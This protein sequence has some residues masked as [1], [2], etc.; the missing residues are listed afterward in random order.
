[1]SIDGGMRSEKTAKE[2]SIDIAKF[3]RYACGSTCLTP[4]WTRL[5]DRDQL[6]GYLQNLDRAKGGPDG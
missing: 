5:T 2:M 4:D 1:M 6:I 3:L